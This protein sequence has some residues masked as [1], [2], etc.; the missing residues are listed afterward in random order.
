MTANSSSKVISRAIWC[1]VYKRKVSDWFYSAERDG[2][3]SDA[4]ILIPIFLLF[5]GHR[6]EEKCI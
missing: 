3:F 1:P 5:K 4:S 6:A 2:T